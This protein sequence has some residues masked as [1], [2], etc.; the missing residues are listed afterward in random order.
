MLYRAEGKPVKIFSVLME[1]AK[2][3]RRMIDPISAIPLGINQARTLEMSNV[4]E[5]NDIGA[6]GLDE[7]DLLSLSDY[8]RSGAP[9]RRRRRESS[10]SSVFR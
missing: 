4:T 2:T 5:H 9:H 3:G 1:L 6:F 10:V 8:L 7:S